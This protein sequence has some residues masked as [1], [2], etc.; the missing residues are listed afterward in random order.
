LKVIFKVETGYSGC[1]YE[2]DIEE[3][4]DDTT[5]EELDTMAINYM[6]EATNIQPYYEIVED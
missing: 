4:P 5:T 3:L 6:W 2:S 1:S